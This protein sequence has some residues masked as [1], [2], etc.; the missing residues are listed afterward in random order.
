MKLIFVSC[1]QKNRII[2]RSDEV[3]R[4][5]TVFETPENV[6]R[7]F[8]IETNREKERREYYFQVPNNSTLFYLIPNNH[9]LH[10]L[11]QK[12]K[13][14]E[15]IYYYNWWIKKKNETLVNPRG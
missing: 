6:K 5:E 2:H 1:A 10:I 11:F 7:K 3:H 15:M 12:E 9:N 14:K 8:F 4:R 13:E